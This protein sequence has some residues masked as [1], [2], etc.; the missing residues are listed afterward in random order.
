MEKWL[1]FLN[2]S[3][4]IALF[5]PAVEKPH[6]FSS[7]FGL[8]QYSPALLGTA[9]EMHHWCALVRKCAAAEK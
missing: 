3:R 7:G 8:G 6:L 2:Y 4:P 5:R 9:A 1:I